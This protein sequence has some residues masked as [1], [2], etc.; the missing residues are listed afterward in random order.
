[1]NKKELIESHKAL[2]GEYSGWEKVG[3]KQG[4]ECAKQDS[5][6]LIQQLDEPQA[7]KRIVFGDVVTV[8][9]LEERAKKKPVAVVGISKDDPKC[10]IHSKNPDWEGWN[11]SGSL[12]LAYCLRYS[13]HP[14]PWFLINTDTRVI[15]EEGPVIHWND[16]N[17]GVVSYRD[18]SGIVR[19]KD[20]RGVDAEKLYREGRILYYSPITLAE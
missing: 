1:M 12:K 13:H 8:A 5:L 3:Y 9:E 14:G 11:G 17:V 20:A 6:N 2:G 19:H 16:V 4:Y 15:T 10:I 7:P 18:E